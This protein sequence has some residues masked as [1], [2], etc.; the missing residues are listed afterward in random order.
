MESSRVPQANSAPGGDNPSCM[1]NLPDP[2]IEAPRP[3]VFAY[4][5]QPGGKLWRVGLFDG[6]VESTHSP[7]A[8]INGD[9]V[10]LEGRGVGGALGGGR[11]E[12]GQLRAVDVGGSQVQSSFCLGTLL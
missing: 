1:G 2:Q 3:V 7:P 12:L 9:G 6:E 4:V 8:L 5:G 10:G 11:V